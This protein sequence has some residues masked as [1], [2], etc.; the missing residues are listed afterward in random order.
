[1]GFEY[2]EL[3]TP[4]NDGFTPQW[5]YP[6]SRTL[7]VP[8]YKQE[9]TYWCGPASIQMMISYNGK[10]VEQKD[11]AKEAGTTTQGSN[12]LDLRNVLNKHIDNHTFGVTRIG[13][14]DY[15]RLFNIIN[16]NIFTKSQPVL[17]LVKTERL[18]YYNGHASNHYI[19]AR[20][21]TKYIDDGT[22][23]PVIGL[24][25]V[26]VVDPHHNNNYYGYF[27]V[28]YNDFYNAVNFNWVEAY[29]I[30]Y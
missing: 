20:G 28:G 18:P 27:T 29:N 14:S 16:S 15:T 26:R 4:S 3:Y 1:M 10:F 24:S 17:A 5:V 8:R 9:T 6:I 12:T 19:V 23:Q 2:T 11:L 25:E 13:S 30:S 21:L 7:S 22:G